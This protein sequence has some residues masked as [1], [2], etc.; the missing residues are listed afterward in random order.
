MSVDGIWTTE[1]M[2]LF[3]W[4]S[5]GVLLLENGRAI[6]GSNVHYSVGSYD[7]SSNNIHLTL[8]VEFHG[9][10]RTIFG[11][12]DKNISIEFNGEIQDGVIEGSAYRTD[13]PEQDIV[14]RLTRRADIPPS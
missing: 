5:V 3:G 1:L 7:T 2:G 9:P 14:Y 4:E 10:P 12:S 11:A 8:D 6:G 13:N